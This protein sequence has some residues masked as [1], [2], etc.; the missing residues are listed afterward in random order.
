M[1]LVIKQKKN[2]PQQG[3]QTVARMVRM[4][5][6]RAMRTNTEVKNVIAYGNN[7]SLAV[8]AAAPPNLN[9]FPQI[10]QGTTN[11]TRIGNSVRIVGGKIKLVIALLPYSAISNPQPAGLMCRLSSVSNATINTNTLGSTAVGSDIFDAGSTNI[12]PQ[13]NLLDICLPVN[14]NN[15]TEYDVKR[16]EIGST[17]GSSTG[18]LSTGM[19]FDNST[20]CK[21]VEFDLP[22][23]FRGK[24]VHY[25]D[26]SNVATNVNAWILAF[27]NYADGTTTGGYTPARWSYVVQLDYTDV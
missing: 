24:V 17:Y 5:V 10:P 3:P 9:W 21:Y 26:G 25:D 4:E 14:K 7:I 19:M 1:A 20:A 11:G 8:S 27:L 12:G 2:K 23:A 15:W 22:S 13:V 18:Q 6:A 16:F